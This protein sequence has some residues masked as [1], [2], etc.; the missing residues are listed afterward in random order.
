[1]SEYGLEIDKGLAMIPYLRQLYGEE[2]GF[3]VS[4]IDKYVLYQRGRR[5]DHGI[6]PGDPVKKGGLND[7]AMSSA[8]RVTTQVSADVFGFPYRGVGIPLMEDGC[9]VGSMTMFQ[10]VEIQDK[11]QQMARKMSSSVE[12]VS[13]GSSGLAASAEELA[14]TSAEFATNT[15]KIRDDVKEM[16]AIITLVREIASQTHLL[17]LNAA[18]EA[19]RAGDLGRGF[20]VVA[21]EV[22]KL[23]GH[24]QSSAKEVAEKLN[25][26]KNTI[27]ALAEHVLQV[28]AV[29]EEQAATSEEI[30]SNIHDIEPMGKELITVSRQLLQ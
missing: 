8:G 26:I 25:R 6:T 11:L 2:V 1:M 4:T 30:S 12:S 23:A 19:A 15:E 7:Q 9:V 20:N 28:A 21:E 14:A 16:D 22:R 13:S 29:S 24:T 17:G 5:M 27:D 10:S 3:S 18:I